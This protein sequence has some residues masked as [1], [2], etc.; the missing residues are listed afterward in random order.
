MKSE[1][2]VNVQYQYYKIKLWQLKSTVVQFGKIVVKVLYSNLTNCKVGQRTLLLD[3]TG[4]SDHHNSCLN[5]K[6][7]KPWCQF[8]TM[9]NLVPAYLTKKFTWLNNVHW[10]KLRTSDYNGFVSRANTEAYKRS[11]F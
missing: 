3:Q 9:N 7:V 11:F 2:E 10:H 4:V 8:K 5:Y 6:L 1:K